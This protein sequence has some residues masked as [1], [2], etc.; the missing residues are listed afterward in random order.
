MT[1]FLLISLSAIVIV[2]F[3]VLE[4]HGDW[5]LDDEDERLEWEDDED[6]R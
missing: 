1:W 4:V 2:G 6:E 3:L 5:W